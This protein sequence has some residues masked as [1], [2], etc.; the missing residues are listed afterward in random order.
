M[1]TKL[2]LLVGATLL[3]LVFGSVGIAAAQADVPRVGT[4][5]LAEQGAR[6]YGVIETVEGQ[7]LTL[8]TPVGPVVV[9]TDANTLFRIPDVE[10]SSL[11]DGSTELAEIL[12]IGD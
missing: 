3:A 6:L 4:G 12:A 9:V 1:S 2:A 7:S 11:D 5:I 8:T 10:K